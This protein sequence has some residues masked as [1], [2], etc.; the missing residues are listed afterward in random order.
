MLTGMSERVV[1]MRV[2]DVELLVEV[3]PVASGG[4]QPTSALGEATKRVADGFVHAEQA[5][6]AVA[7]SMA[8]TVRRLGDE[9]ARPDRLEVEF[10]LKFSLQGDV[11][12]ASASGEASLRVLVGYDR[13]KQV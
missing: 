8:G 13:S 3:S 5:I 12:L 11:I 2:G 10:G 6:M 4:T 9:A 1:S 7:S